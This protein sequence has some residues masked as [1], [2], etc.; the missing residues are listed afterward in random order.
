MSDKLSLLVLNDIGDAVSSCLALTKAD[1][2]KCAY[3]SP[4]SAIA[5]LAYADGLI[6]CGGVDIDPTHYGQIPHVLTQSP[7]KAR[8]TLELTALRIAETL[9]LPVLGI[10]R[11]NQIMNVYAGGTLVQ[12]LPKYEQHA[13]ATC[14]HGIKTVPRSFVR[15]IYG[16]QGNVTSF[17]HQA[18]RQLGAGFRATARHATDRTIEAIEDGKRKWYGVQFHPEWESDPVSYRFFGKFVSVCYQAKQEKKREKIRYTYTYG[19]A[20]KTGS[21]WDNSVMYDSPARNYSSEDWRNV[22]E[23]FE[24]HN[25]DGKEENHRKGKEGLVGYL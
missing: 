7:I 22:E 9:K 20:S 17:H 14:Y 24:E 23:W 2:Q 5:S 21:K 8:D 10:C 15:T 13:D 25:Y 19:I 4:E 12:H 1:V 6:I 3:Y 18:V 11:G 16:T